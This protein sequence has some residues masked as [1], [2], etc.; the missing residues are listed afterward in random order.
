MSARSTT[1]DLV[2]YDVDMIA[3]VHMDNRG[4]TLQGVYGSKEVIYDR[5]ATWIEANFDATNSIGWELLEEIETAK[6]QHGTHWR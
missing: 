2:P 5:V 6:K 1:L 4:L 3:N